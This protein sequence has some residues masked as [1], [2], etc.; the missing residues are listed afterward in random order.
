MSKFTKVLLAA[1]ISLWVLAGVIV[2]MAGKYQS[3]LFSLAIAA[4]FFIIYRM[5]ELDFRIDSEMPHAKK[6]LATRLKA[7]WERPGVEG[8]LLLGFLL[9]LFGVW[10]SQKAFS[11]IRLFV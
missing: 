1:F 2:A 7:Y 8:K 6:N 11:L 10:I 3:S 9:L 4:S 5:A